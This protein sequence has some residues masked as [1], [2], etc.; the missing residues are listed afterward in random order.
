[1]RFVVIACLLA[2]GCS[3]KVSKSGGGSGSGGSSGSSGTGAAAGSGGSSG[4][5]TGGNAGSDAGTCTAAACSAAPLT[6]PSNDTFADLLFWPDKNIVVASG[7]TSS[8]GQLIECAPEAANCGS[9]KAGTNA[10]SHLAVH[11]SKLYVAADNQIDSYSYTTAL[12][13][14][15]TLSPKLVGNEA[16]GDLAT[17]DKYLY[18]SVV[19]PTGPTAIRQFNPSSDAVYDFSQTEDAVRVAIGSS[20]LFFTRDTGAYG[21]M[22]PKVDAPTAVQVGQ[23]GSTSSLALTVVSDGKLYFTSNGPASST[24]FT[25]NGTTLNGTKELIQTIPSNIA[26]MTHDDQGNVFLGGADGSVYR[27]AVQPVKLDKLAMLPDPVV[28]IAISQKM[29]LTVATTSALYRV[30]QAHQCCGL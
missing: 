23:L 13:F 29:A 20:R 26:C 17:D 24:L 11:G 16:V 2:L 25:N 18:F 19:T 4:S 12:T 7:A 3:S 22:L 28:G 8:G 5:A 9:P 6:S 14:D 30:S 1:M 15:S 21:L 27:A 10:Y